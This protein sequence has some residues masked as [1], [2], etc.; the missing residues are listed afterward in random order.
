MAARLLARSCK[1]KVNPEKNKLLLL[2]DTGGVFYTIE[3]AKLP[4]H[5][6]LKNYNNLD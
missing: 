6:F 3:Q 1:K 2:A 4:S 5:F